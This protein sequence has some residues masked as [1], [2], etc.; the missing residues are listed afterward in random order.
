RSGTE[1][2][3][4]LAG[5]LGSS[6]GQLLRD[7]AGL[8][9]AGGGAKVPLPGVAEPLG[10]SVLVPYGIPRATSLAQLAGRFGSTAQQLAAA[11]AAMPGLLGLASATVTVSAGSA[12]TDVQAGDSLAAI[13]VRLQQ[14]Q[15]T[16]TLADL[17]STIEANPAALA[18]DALLV[19]PAP[20]LAA[21]VPA[22]AAAPFG[23]SPA[24][25]LQANAALLGFVR[26]GVTLTV[27]DPTSDVRASTRTVPH[28]T[29]NAILGRLAEAGVPV[30][31]AGL[32]AQ[33]PTA[34]LL[35]PT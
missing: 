11:N 23:V 25:L 13:V 27:T 5:L 28:D 2:L 26:P 17:V 10:A 20:T 34:E 32:L 7:N 19:C 18:A 31:I 21:S 1:Q 6:L 3:G 24:G 9:L 14:Q 30:D 33:N 35:Q 22:D 29:V 4:Q 15:P 12:S 8:P 16:V